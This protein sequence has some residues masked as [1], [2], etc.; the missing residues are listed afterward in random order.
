[1]N[2]VDPGDFKLLTDLI[3]ER[4]GLTLQGVRQEI[5]ASRLQPRLRELHLDSP[6]D[7]YEY[8]RYHPD[9]DAEFGRLPAMVTNNETYFFREP[10]QFDLLIKHV[11]PERR[12][13]L[14]T[15]PLR[16]L[17]AGCS[18]GEEPYSLAITLHDAGLPLSG[19][20]WEIDAC[21]L[22]P[23]RIARAREGIYEETSLRACDPDVRRRYFTEE[24]R[25]FHVR[26]RYRSGV[27]F[28]QANL[29]APNGQLG[30]AVYDAIFCRNLLIYFG[31]T[32]FDN[33]INLFARCLVPGGYLFLGH[34]ESLIDRTTA[35][36]PVVMGSVI[37]R[38]AA[39][40]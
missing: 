13:A 31:E 33:V 40:Q 5:F 4:F 17:S 1:M 3:Q 39:G 37:Y 2:G 8:L 34:S 23:D 10:H 19:V 15:R 36:E 12:T 11:L 32:A 24:G 14:R 21:D 27:R 26:P 20:A 25:R 6:R 30:W 9:R 7:Y 28:F 29:L 38:K 22:N 18:S 35:F 16:I